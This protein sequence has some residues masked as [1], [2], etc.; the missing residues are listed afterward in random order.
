MSKKKDMEE[1]VGNVFSGLTGKDTPKKEVTTRK[2]SSSTSKKSFTLEDTTPA[3]TP[4][5]G[6]TKKGR[7]KFTTM[8]KPELRDKLQNIADNNALS[9]ADVLETI[10]EEY[11]NLK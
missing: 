9:V 1:K 6:L 4:E 3:P 5:P 11:F 2:T 10:I 8:L 7:V